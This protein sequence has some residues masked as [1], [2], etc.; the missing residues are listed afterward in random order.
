MLRWALLMRRS[1]FKL[2]RVDE[3]L[4]IFG[5]CKRISI[6]S[7]PKVRCTIFRSS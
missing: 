6:K 1:E 5:D 7:S 2:R 3:L 4:D